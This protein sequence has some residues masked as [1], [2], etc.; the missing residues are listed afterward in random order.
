MPYQ[1]TFKPLDISKCN[2]LSYL[3]P[4]DQFLS[5]EPLWF[6]A[7][8][9]SKSLSRRQMLSWVKRFA[10]GLEKLGVEENRAIMTFTPN[11][12]YVPM[13]Y[14]AA[15]GSKRIFTGANPVYTVEELAHQM[16][17][18]EAGVVFI[19]PTLLEKGLAAAKK[20]GIP[21]ERIFQFADTE[22]EIS[23]NIQDWRDMAASEGDAQLWKWDPLGESSV[24]Q[25]AAINFSSGT[26]GLPKGVCVTH[27]NLVSNA[28]QVTFT[29]FHGTGHSIHEANPRN[30][31]WLAFLPLYHAYSQ[32]FTIN[33][34]C[35]LEIPVYVMPHFGYQDFLS[36]IERFRITSLQAIPPVL[37]MLAKR[38]ETKNYDISSLRSIMC[39]AAPMALSLQN[40]ISARFNVSITQSW[41]MTETTCVGTMTPGTTN[42]QSGSIGFLLPNTEAKL[43]DLAENEVQGDEEPGELWLRGPQIMAKYWKNR[44]AT[45]E[46]ITENG[47][48]RTGDIA[49]VRDNMWWIVDRKKELIKVNGLQVAP[50][51]LEAVLLRHPEVADVAVVGITIH[52]EE[53]PR[54]YVVLQQSA[55][56]GTSEVC[57]QDF[58]KERVAKH[59]ALAGGVK[60]VEAIPKLGSGKIVRSTMKQWAKTDAAELEAQSKPRL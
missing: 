51:E 7:A 59:K 53:L 2:I 33:L 32:L 28:S 42:D 56:G 40:E 54:A 34:A 26:T 18:V 49:I 24:N 13:A 8:D 46:T 55:P 44:Q 39:G 4:E 10:L 23:L 29:K 5:N 16:K 20:A 21:C 58:V 27:F 52:G 9:T 45:E 36:Y 38:G 41:G 30:E 22:C 60:F 47:W 48:L 57:I 17:T 37:I 1:S 6:S 19:H 15:A 43:V 31:R 35:K 3:F 14:L 25:I 12:I 11:H 50:A